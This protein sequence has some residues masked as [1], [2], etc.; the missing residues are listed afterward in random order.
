MSAN[1]QIQVQKMTGLTADAYAEAVWS[2]ALEY[3]RYYTHGQE[4]TTELLLKTRSFWRWW[5]REWEKADEIFISQYH[6]YSGIG[7]EKYLLVM[8]YDAHRVE[9]IVSYP[10]ED[11]AL[12]F[13]ALLK[14]Q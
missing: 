3:C 6:N 8:Y 7:E 13:A 12:E 9:Q 1:T 5:R 10:G 4:N 14:Q 11:V 2:G